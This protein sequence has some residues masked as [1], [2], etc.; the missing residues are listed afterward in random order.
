MYPRPISSVHVARYHAALMG[1]DEKIDTFGIV[2][3]ILTIAT[4]IALLIMEF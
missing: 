3:G 4:V 2:V 1:H